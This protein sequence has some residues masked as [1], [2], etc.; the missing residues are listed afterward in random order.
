MA[1]GPF[2][3]DDLGGIDLLHRVREESKHLD[4]PGVR[5]PLVHDR[6]FETG[7]YGQ[8]TGAGWYRYDEK[9]NASPDPFTKELVEKTSGELG[10]ARRAITDEEIIERCIYVMVNEGAKIL[11]EGIASRALDIN[12]IYTTGYG[13]P[14]WRGGPMWFADA[15]GLKKIY[16]RICVFEKQYGPELWA[17]A[18]LLKELVEKGSTFN[19]W[20]QKRL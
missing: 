14:A 2:A 20:D 9:G 15:I 5:K 10:I 4:K 18:P 13:F 12:V 6:M 3:V 1:M 11:S 17:P 19:E 7:R 8:K 16:E